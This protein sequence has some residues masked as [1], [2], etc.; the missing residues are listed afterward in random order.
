ML[1]GG[2]LKDIKQ[3]QEKP[4]MYVLQTVNMYCWE[5]INKRI[6]LGRMSSLFI[7]S[8]II[9]KL[10]LKDVILVKRVHD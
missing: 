4:D 5:F 1:Y 6:L 3:V 7:S 8:W 9:Y 10:E 2:L